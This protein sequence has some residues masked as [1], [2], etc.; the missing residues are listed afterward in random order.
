[1]STPGNCE[2]PAVPLPPDTAFLP[3]SAR[4]AMTSTD[5]RPA[6]G[7]FHHV[8]VTGYHLPGLDHDDVALLQERRSNFFLDS[9]SAGLQV[10]EPPGDGGGFRFAQRF[11]LGF[12]AAFGHRLREIREKHGQP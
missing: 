5:A 4:Y 10:L 9:R 1:M 11:G 3:I 2:C 6:F 8:A 12:A 7:G